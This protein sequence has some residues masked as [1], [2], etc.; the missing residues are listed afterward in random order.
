[1][2]TNRFT[3]PKAHTRY[4]F[5]AHVA[6]WDSGDGNADH[7]WATSAWLSYRVSAACLARWRAIEYL[8][9]H[10]ISFITAVEGHYQIL[11]VADILVGGQQQL[12]PGLFRCGE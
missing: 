2:G 1:V 3:D 8:S 5:A 10:C 9:L 11:L 12:E 7:V 4:R 6:L